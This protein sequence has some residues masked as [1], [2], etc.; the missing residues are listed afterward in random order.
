MANDL[1][2]VIPQILSQAMMIL[3]G[4]TIMPR[5]VSTEY[6]SEAA[7]KGSSIDVPKD[8]VVTTRDVVPGANQIAADAITPG[9]VQIPLDFWKE[10]PFQMTDNDILKA[11]LGTLPSTAR[12]AVAS[13][14]AAI[15]SYLFSMYK[16][17]YGFIGTAG[18]PPFAGTT[19]TPADA[20]QC[21]KL[22]N[23]QLA[24]INARRMVLDPEAAANALNLGAFQDASKSA[25]SMVVTDAVL[26]RKIG[27]DWYEDQ[28]VPVHTA[29]TIASALI[30]KASTAQAI[31]LTNIV[32]TSDDD[33]DL[34]EGDI[35]SF[36][37]STQTYVVTADTART[38]AGD[39]TVPIQPP[40]VKA[41][42]GSEV[43]TLKASHTVNLAFQEGAFAFVSRPLSDAT[44]P[45]AEKASII[46]S[47]TDALSGLSLRLEITRQHKQWQ[48]AFDLLGGAACID[49]KKVARLGG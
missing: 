15:N 29:G 11:Q 28:Q 4:A 40:L 32:C 20:T 17:V 22:L 47:V 2:N 23:I 37:G 9:I 7:T 31:G 36:A 38:G 6:Q 8:P 45:G 48:W 30:A 41:L 49:P 14:A 35:I 24:P 12:S 21:R 39:V 33:I 25:D 18:S 43:V 19:P 26:G 34:L 3:R 16:S 44:P 46:E 42:V 10:A 13:L 27:F 5:L 1:A